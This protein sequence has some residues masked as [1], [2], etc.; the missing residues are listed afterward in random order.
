MTLKDTQV[1]SAACIQLPFFGT[2]S[3]HSQH[4]SQNFT[5]LSQGGK[6][7]EVKIIIII[8]AIAVENNSNDLLQLVFSYSLLCHKKTSTKLHTTCLNTP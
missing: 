1:K 6:A 2:T 4:V 5:F 7:E 8:P 3:W